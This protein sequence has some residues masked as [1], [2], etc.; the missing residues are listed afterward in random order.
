MKMPPTWVFGYFPMGEGRLL[1][2]CYD[3]LTFKSIPGVKEVDFER[4]AA[5]SAINGSTPSNCRQVS[6][7]DYLELF[8]A[9]FEA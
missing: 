1:C 7:S 4:L 2:V 3:T 8:R 6:E 5:A 9:A